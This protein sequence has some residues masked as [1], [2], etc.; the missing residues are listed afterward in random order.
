MKRTA[1]AAWAVSMVW[2][3]CTSGA[4]AREQAAAPLATAASAATPA[5]QATPAVQAA[6]SIV[7][8]AQR[9]AARA[10]DVASV[11]A[12]IQALYDVVSGPAGPRD[13]DRLRSLF[14]PDGKMAAIGAQKSGG[15]ALRSMTV[16]DY[17]ARNTKAFSE[18]GFFESELA[19]TTETFGQLV[20]VFSTYQ[21]KRAPTDAKPMMRG[22][23]SMQL[24]SD[25]TRWYIVSLVWRAEDDRLTLP[26]R[27][28]KQ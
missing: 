20:H 15:F 16:D 4:L 7:M 22:I 8:Q 9:P 23:N 13:W 10:A 19:R 3:G 2:M 6:P 11:D 12:I 27:Y 1:M 24:Y 5:S 26:E 25:G 17:I 28:L 21:A 18:G 14:T